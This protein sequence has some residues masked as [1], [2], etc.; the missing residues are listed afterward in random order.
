MRVREVYFDVATG[1]Q[2]EREI[3]MPDVITAEEAAVKDAAAVKAA[4]ADRA[5]WN[6]IK[7][8]I[9]QLAVNP[10]QALTNAQRDQA[11][12]T[13]AFAVKRLAKRMHTEFD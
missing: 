13:L 5:V 1:E 4:A 12:A 6:T 8:R 2:G 9:N 7:D 11:I 10:P 3:E